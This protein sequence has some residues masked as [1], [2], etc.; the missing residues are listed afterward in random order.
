MK[1]DLV[2][3]ADSLAA[4]A[5]PLAE[6]QTTFTCASTVQ[7]EISYTSTLLR[8]HF[9]KLNQKTALVLPVSEAV[10]ALLPLAIS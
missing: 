5:S 2:L 3:L 9:R 6:R 8:L 10:F 4:F 7:F 1:F